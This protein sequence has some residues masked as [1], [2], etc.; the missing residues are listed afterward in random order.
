MMVTFQFYLEHPHITFYGVQPPEWS[1]YVLTH[2]HVF[3]QTAVRWDQHRLHP[4]PH[5]AAA[6]ALHEDVCV[7]VCVRGGKWISVALSFPPVLTD[8]ILC[9][10]SVLNVLYYFLSSPLCET[11]PA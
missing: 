5:A 3:A 11:M 6:C 8:Y 9:R 4:T 1:L 10:D 7:C 2:P